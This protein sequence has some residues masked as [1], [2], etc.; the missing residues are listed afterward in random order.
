[1]FDRSYPY[2]ER[3]IDVIASIDATDKSVRLPAVTVL[4]ECMREYIKE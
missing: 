3:H 2:I 1:M 4:R